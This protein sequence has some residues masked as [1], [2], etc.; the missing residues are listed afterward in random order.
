MPARNVFALLHTQIFLIF[1]AARGFA[2]ECIPI[3]P[4]DALQFAVGK[5]TT[6]DPQ[7]CDTHAP[8]LMHIGQQGQLFAVEYVH[9][10]ELIRHH[11]EIHIFAVTE[12]K[13]LSAAWHG[14]F[15]RIKPPEEAAQDTVFRNH[16]RE[17]PADNHGERN[18]TILDKTF[19][20]SAVE[21]R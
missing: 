16:E 17:T 2:P 13:F 20:L 9:T 5:T 3:H 18:G 6:L 11:R 1:L 12:E 14:A 21:L 7:G 10:T 8:N 15:S 19:H 4:N